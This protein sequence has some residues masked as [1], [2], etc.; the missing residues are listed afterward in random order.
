M[1]YSIQKKELELVKVPTP[2]TAQIKKPTL[3]K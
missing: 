1:N 2:K 3:L